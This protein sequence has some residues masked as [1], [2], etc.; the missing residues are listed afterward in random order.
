MPVM[1]AFSPLSNNRSR[2]RSPVLSQAGLSSFD[3]KRSESMEE[4]RSFLRGKKLSM[5]M[6]DRS[7]IPYGMLKNHEVVDFDFN[8]IVSAS[9]GY[10]PKQVVQKY[11]R[12]QLKILESLSDEG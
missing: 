11:V 6:G 8:K 10:L 2:N 3:L 9:K 7:R 12:E 1:P 5:D 4:P